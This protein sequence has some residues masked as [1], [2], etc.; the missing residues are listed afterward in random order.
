MCIR[1]RLK[2]SKIVILDEATS[3]VDPENEQELV[4]ALND[5]LKDKTV[6]VIAHK[7]ETIKSSDQIIVMDLSLI[8]ISLISCTVS[9][10]T[11]DYYMHAL[12]VGSVSYTHLDVYK[13][14]V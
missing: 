8:H 4:A 5:L 7:L 3:S 10:F 12:F 1:D 2:P 9:I 14:Q 11:K 6:I 13:R